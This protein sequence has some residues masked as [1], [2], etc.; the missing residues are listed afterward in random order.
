MGEEAYET[1]IDLFGSEQGI[2]DVDFF[3]EEEEES[4]EDP[5][6]EPGLNG[7][8]E[9][10]EEEE[11]VDDLFDDESSAE[12]SNEDPAPGT[13]DIPAGNNVAVLNYMVENGLIEEFELE[14]GEELTEDLAAE[15]LEDTNDALFNDKITKIFEEMPAQLRELNSF[16][17]KG[18]DMNTYLAKISEQNKEGIPSGLDMTA[19]ANQVLVMTKKY[20]KDGHDSEYITAQIEFLK[21]SNNLEKLSS[22]EYLK[23]EEVKL[24]E[25]AAVVK[26]QEASLLKQKTERRAIKAKVSNF[27][28]ETEE[29]EGFKVT[30]VDKRILPNYM[31]DRSIALDNGNSITAMQKDLMR[32]LN[33]EVGSVQIAKLLRAANENGELNFK[34]IADKAKTTVTQQVRDN[35]RRKRKSVSPAPTPNNKIRLADHFN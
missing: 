19:E 11:S 34:E 26:S 31:S 35:I 15:Y 17:I 7:T 30:K 9:E 20:S 6:N 24:A 23:S 5:N 10:E 21:D 12:D 25:R 1:E 28:A 22:K 29:I 33:S 32:V 13:D 16:V 3:K 8:E 2:P 14:E 18:G 27:L 4:I